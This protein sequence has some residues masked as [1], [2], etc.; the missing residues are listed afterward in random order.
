M[1]T[2]EKMMT[3]EE[4]HCTQIL[5][6]PTPPGRYLRRSAGIFLIFPADRADLRRSKIKYNYM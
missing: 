1:E 2:A 6:T 5:C 3:C 4:W